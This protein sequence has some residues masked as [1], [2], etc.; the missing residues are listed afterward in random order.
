[1][2]A[3]LEV[4]QDTSLSLCEKRGVDSREIDLRKRWLQIS[5]D[6]ER[7]LESLQDVAR[8]NGDALIDALYEHF[9]L[10]DEPKRILGDSISRLK[11]SQ[12]EYFLGLTAGDYGE[13]YF[14][15]RLV[16]GQVH[17]R[18]GL[19]PKWYLGAYCMYIRLILPLIL[20]TTGGD[21][22]RTLDLAQSLLKMIFLDMGLAIEMYIAAREE[23]RDR[24]QRLM[25][26]AATRLEGSSAALSTATT[27]QGAATAEQAS[28]IN[29][30]TATIAEIRQTSAQALEKAEGVIQTAEQSSAAS[31]I[32]AKAVEESINAMQQIR[33]QVESIAEKILALSEQTQQ[34]GEIIATVNDIAEQSKLL[35]LNA[36]IE[37]AR[38]G[39]H[40]KG[41]AVVAMEIR[42]LAD[43]SKQ[44]TVQVRKILGEIQKATNSAVM[45]TEEGSKRAES[46]VDLANRAG[47]NIQQLTVAIEESAAMAKQISGSAKQQ[48]AG[49]EQVSIGMTN[50][51]KAAAGTLESIRSTEQTAREL[52]D[53]S[54][55]IKDLAS[56][57]GAK[58]YKGADR[59]HGA[60]TE[61]AN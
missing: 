26:E 32:G 35:A 10:F 5:D 37:A 16:I 28:A 2:T 36:S 41:F 44:A 42:S 33:E 12:K 34:I 22:Q 50:I 1:M 43:Q 61:G 45:V 9:A 3:V 47:Q 18:V 49:I 7:N 11:K 30:I 14:E 38:A 21:A 58:S 52:V 48:N 46:G 40:G 53:L 59:R 23:G 15:R 20:D 57:Y 39:E 51:N 27:Q 31:Q 29:E 24:T 4:D 25:M 13:K 60:T 17:D 56:L 19:E 8:M 55:S 6:D 54:R